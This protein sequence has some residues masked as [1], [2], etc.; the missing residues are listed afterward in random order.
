MYAFYLLASRLFIPWVEGFL[1]E[2][3]EKHERQKQLNEV[4]FQ[5]QL[6]M[7]QQAWQDTE[8]HRKRLERSL[9]DLHNNTGEQS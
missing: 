9:D 3:R 1:A 8:R 2:R 7:A 4:L 5:Q 6:T